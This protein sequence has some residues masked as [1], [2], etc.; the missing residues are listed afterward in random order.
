VLWLFSNAKIVAE[1]SGAATVAAALTAKPRLR[2]PVVAVVS[3]GNIG[4]DKLEEL[5]QSAR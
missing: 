1:P 3:G 2:G 5:R 4:M